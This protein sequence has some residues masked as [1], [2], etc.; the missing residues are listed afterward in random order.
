MST[1]IEAYVHIDWAGTGLLFRIFMFSEIFNIITVSNNKSK[2]D[3]VVWIKYERLILK[4]SL[5]PS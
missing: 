5:Q 4:L 3:T 1:K 2:I